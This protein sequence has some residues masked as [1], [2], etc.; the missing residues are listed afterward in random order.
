MFLGIETL[1]TSILKEM[2]KTQNL[3]AL[4]KND[5]AETATLFDLQ[6]SKIEKLR[7][8]GMGVFAGFMVG[9]D[10]DDNGSVRNIIRFLE[11]SHIPIAGLTILQA[12]PGT[13]LYSKMS[14]EKRI[15]QDISVLTQPF[16]SNVILKK[17]PDQFYKGFLYCVEKIYGAKPYFN[18]CLEW[19]TK[20]NDAYLIPGRRGSV[21]A[22]FSF[23][24]LL[25][26]LWKQ[27]LRS[28]YRKDY[29]IYIIKIISRFYKDPNRLSIS[30][31]LGYFYEIMSDNLTATRNFV[32]NLPET[33][34]TEWKNIHL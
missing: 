22:N 30:L 15:S 16:R 2:K 19:V 20:W 24:R 13:P 32:N 4:D 18:R 3:R 27:G 7:S 23:R 26:S 25:R 34:V 14:E 31:F 12:P 6:I 17:D 5:N 33:L 28:T 29:W 8:Y 11:Q 1:N 21:S 9:F 10:E